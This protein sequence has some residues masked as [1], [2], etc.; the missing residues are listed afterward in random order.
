MQGLSASAASRC[1]HATSKRCRCRCGG[2][3]HG[4]ARTDP[5]NPTAVYLLDEGDPHLP[6]IPPG[7]GVQL[8]LYALA[9][10]YTGAP[11]PPVATTA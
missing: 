6:P 9:T 3:Y 10:G 8:A 11:A 4:A 1:E 2:A 5:T 7:A